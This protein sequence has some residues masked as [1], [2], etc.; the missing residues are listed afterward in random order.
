MARCAFVRPET[1]TI[2]LKDGDWIRVKKHLTAGEEKRLSGAGLVSLSQA[3]SAQAGSP[4]SAFELDFVRLGLATIEAYVVAWSFVGF[5]GNQT[6]PTPENIAALDPAI[7]AEIQDALK[8]HIVAMR[9]DAKRPQ[10][11]TAGA[12]S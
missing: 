1:V 11:A 4:K 5:D 7:E 10:S 12:P 2:Q 3:A 6:E 8:A 9:E